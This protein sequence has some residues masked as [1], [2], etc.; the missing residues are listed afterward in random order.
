M[1]ADYY[2]S[3]LTLERLRCGILAPFVDGFVDQLEAKGYTPTSV[4]AYL[5]TAAHLGFWGANQELQAGDLDETMI[6]AFL[7][8]LPSCTCFR[9]NTG[10]YEA[11]P[12]H[13]GF[14]LGRLREQGIL[15]RRATDGPASEP[16]LLHDF[17]QWML[18]H[19][20]VTEATL[21]SYRPV[22]AGLLDTVEGDVGRLGPA[23]IRAF[24][25]QWGRR[26]TR[27]S[28]AGAT[29]AMRM[30]LRY[31]AIEGRVHPGLVC[32]VPSMANWALSSL[33]RYLPAADIEKIVGHWE[34]TSELGARNR[35]ILL[36]LARLGLRA[37]DVVSMKLNDIDW[38]QATIRVCGKGRCE[39][40]LP[41]T[42]EVG[43]A[44]IAHLAY[45]RHR[46]NDIHVFVRAR[47]PF[48]PL[49]AHG[50]V[51]VMVA[52]TLA[53][54]GIHSPVRGAHVLRHSAA[55]Q[56][57]R[58]GASLQSIGSVLRH[59]SIDTTEQYAKVDVKTLQLVAQPWPEVANVDRSR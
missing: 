12:G 39:A 20:G 59:R 27:S 54:A 31:L 10:K 49:S 40:L 30:F 6:R 41:L 21:N 37:G 29:G 16:G 48:R 2:S 57:L 9:R 55:T 28:T 11:V 19:R 7:D 25:M 45:R 36:L 23:N 44:L 56:M 47:A 58:E 15:E 43:D 42:Q 32:A 22:L 13:L 38:T 24:V 4:R 8:H 17:R 33:P 14:L 52:R 35:A 5:S 51:S 3:P 53:R 46:G 18:K 1:L 50:T 34:P 26:H